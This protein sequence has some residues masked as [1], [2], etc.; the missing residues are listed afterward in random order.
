MFLLP[1]DDHFFQ[2]FQ[3]GEYLSLARVTLILTHRNATSFVL[4]ELVLSACHRGT[5]HWGEDAH[6]IF[7]ERRYFT[8]YAWVPH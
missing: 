1:A 5:Q 7:L 4:R 6:T 8:G 3:D 2:G